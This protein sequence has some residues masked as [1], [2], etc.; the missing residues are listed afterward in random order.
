MDH[1]EAGKKGGRVMKLKKEAAELGYYLM[2]MRKYDKYLPCSCGGKKR[3]NINTKDN[4]GDPIV[5][6]ECY[7][8]G[9]QVMGFTPKQAKENWNAV[10]QEEGVTDGAE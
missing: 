2:K 4:D 5:I 7:K 9:R 1:I 3:K 6:L 10:M 8:C